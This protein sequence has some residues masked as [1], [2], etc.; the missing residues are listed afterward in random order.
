MNTLLI[1]VIQGIE[2]VVRDELQDLGYE[3]T[4]L[5]TGRVFLEAP[6]AE[7]PRLNAELRTAERV[8]LVLLQL[9]YSS[10]DD[11]FDAVSALDLSWLVPTDAKFTVISKLRS[12]PTIK[13]EVTL[14]RSIKKALV[15]TLKASHRVDTLPE[16]GSLFPFQILVEG[17]EA[18]LAVDT[19]GEGL[20]RRGYRLEC[21]VAPL[22]ETLAAALVRLS[23]WQ[24]KSCPLVDP[25]CG[26]GTILIE[27][28]APRT[29][30]KYL[31]ESWSILEPT[32]SNARLPTLHELQGFDRDRA[33]IEVARNN[34][35]RAGVQI[36]FEVQPIERC[37][38]TDSVIITNPP[39][40]ERLKTDL[41]PIYQ[42]LRR[43]IPENRST[44]ILTADRDLEKH[45]KLPAKRRRKL[46]NGGMRVDLYSF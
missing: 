19:T 9:K 6:L 4:R 26:S 37:T 15:N 7:I 43:L 17:D 40:G 20:H 42:A 2:S 14:Q 13:S 33:A 46:S 36:N 29:N 34:A 35:E 39:Y 8:L 16:S 25:C 3:R 18:I 32:P 31:F 30:R 28:A 45:L 38:V 1:P 22:K 27:A 24:L 10:L 41:R 44:H 23:G 11:L 21:G 5:K 12:S